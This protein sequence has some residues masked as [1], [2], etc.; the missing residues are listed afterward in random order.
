MRRA[1]AAAALPFLLPFI[2]VLVP[3]AIAVFCIFAFFKGILCT[4]PA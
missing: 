1:A 3:F 2:I 4:A